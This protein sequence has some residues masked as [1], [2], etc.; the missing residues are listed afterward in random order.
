[1]IGKV[2]LSEWLVES[3]LYC[4]GLDTWMLLHM[5]QERWTIFLKE[6]SACCLFFCVLHLLS[7]PFVY[8]D[9]RLFLFLSFTWVFW[10]SVLLVPGFKLWSCPSV[11][12]LVFAGLLWIVLF[13]TCWSISAFVLV[14]FRWSL[15]NNVMDYNTQHKRQFRSCK[16]DC[17]WQCG[18]W[19]IFPLAKQS[20]EIPTY[21]VK[22]IINDLAILRYACKPVC[23]LLHLFRSE[24]RDVIKSLPDKIKVSLMLPDLLIKH[25]PNETKV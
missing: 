5:D 23:V 25:W 21:T 7:C 24:R 16:S 12:V 8:W 20:K 14:Y 11:T 1:M 9:V 19:K 4:S 3:K 18:Y 22:I 17:V 15:A 6:I 10:F 13:F 2:H